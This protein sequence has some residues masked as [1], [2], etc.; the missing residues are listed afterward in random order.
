MNKVIDT[1]ERVFMCISGASGTG[2]TQLISSMLTLEPEE[3]PPR[4][5]TTFQ[6]EYKRI[7]Y[8]YRHWQPV[9]DQFISRLTPAIIGFVQAA[10]DEV[11]DKTIEEARPDVKT[12]LIFDDSCEEILQSRS[13]AN[14]ATSGRHK[15]LHV[16]FIKHNVYQQG[17]HCVTVD[18]NTTHL[19]LMKSPRMGKQLKLLGGEID[20]ANRQFLEETYK[21]ATAE[22]FGHLLIDLSPGCNDLLRFCSRVTGHKAGGVTVFYVPESTS[23]DVEQIKDDEQTNDIY[24]EALSNI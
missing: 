3:Q 15:G 23:G 1:T 10:G 2:K 12:L 7:K 20:G 8:F 9:Y 21:R 17:K 18:K 5:Y 16:I 4:Q 24:A 19:I 22:R 14:L 6:P 11:I 13:F